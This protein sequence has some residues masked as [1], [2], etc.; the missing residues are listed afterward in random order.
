MARRDIRMQK[1][2]AVLHRFTRCYG[3][4][5]GVTCRPGVIL[6][7]GHSIVFV[8][9]ALI[10]WIGVAALGYVLGEIYHWEAAARRHRAPKSALGRGCVK[11]M[12]RIA[13]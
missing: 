4:V 3:C 5:F 8:A 9:Y 6:S 12:D 11:T 7:T 13:N 2:S 1:R 10:P